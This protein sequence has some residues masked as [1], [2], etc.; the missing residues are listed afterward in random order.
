M[1]QRFITLLLICSANV[2]WAQIYETFSDNNFTQPLWIGD[3]SSFRINASF[4][5]QLNTNQTGEYTLVTRMDTALPEVW[6]FWI[7][8]AFNPSTQNFTRFYLLSDSPDLTGIPNGYGVQLGGITGN[9]DSIVFF[10]QKG[11]QL[12]RLFGGRPATVGKSNNKISMRISRSPDGW[13]TCYSDTGGGRAWVSEGTVHDDEYRESGWMG[14]Y[15]KV[16]SGNGQQVYLDDI[17]AGPVWKDTVHPVLRE[18]VAEDSVTLSLIFSEPLNRNVAGNHQNYRMMPDDEFAAW[19]NIPDSASHRVWLHFEKP[20]KAMQLYEM[21][22]TGISDTAGNRLKD[23]GATFRYIC[24]SEFDVVI[25][26]LMPDPSPPVDLPETEYLELYNNSGIELNLANWTL[27]DGTTT[28]VLPEVYLQPDSFLIVCSSSNKDLLSAFGPVLALHVFPTLNNSEDE[29]VLRNRKGVNIHTIRYNLSAYRDPGKS[30]GGWSLEMTN[31]KR[32]CAGIFNY[33][34][35]S[36]LSGG[37]PGKRNAAWTTVPDT[38]PPGLVNINAID[39]SVLRV[40][41]N[42]CMDS[43][44]LLHSN[45]LVWPQL[46]V[47]DRQPGS[48]PF[49]TLMLRTQPLQPNT[50]YHFSISG[51]QDCSGNHAEISAGYEYLHAGEALWN[52]VLITEIMANPIGAPAL[53][54]VEFV[55][56]HNRSGHVMSTRNW[57]L[58]DRSTKSTC[59]EYFIKPDS[60]VL[61]VPS[62]AEFQFPGIPCLGLYPFPSLGNE[63]DQL[64]L[65][66]DSGKVLHTVSY[67]KDMF[68][69]D[70]KSEGGWSLEMM[71]RLNPCTEKGNWGASR[72]SSGGTPGAMNSV[73][74]SNPDR[75]APE[76]RQ[77]YP[78]GDRC[79]EIR[80]S[81]PM[82]PSLLRLTG[83]YR[84][85][86]GIGPDSLQLMEPDYREVRLYFGK[87]FQNQTVYGLQVKQQKD[88]AGNDLD[89]YR[90]YP[91]AMPDSIMPGDL[92]INEVLFNPGSGGSDFVEVVNSSKH[93]I[94]LRHIIL[95]NGETDGQN[96]ES[97]KPLPDGYLMAPGSY[98]VF[99]PDPDDILTRFTCASPLQIIS[100]KLPSLPDDAGTVSLLTGAET[101]IESFQY[102]N[103]MHNPFVNQQDGVSLERIQSNRP[104]TDVTNWTSAA[105]T[106][107]YGTPTQVNSQFF[108]SRETESVLQVEPEL[109]S[110]DY[111][112]FKDLIHFSYNLG[113]AGFVGQMVLYHESGRPVRTLM[114]NAVLGQ[115]GTI[116]WD[117]TSDQNGICPPGIY[118]VIFECFHAGGDI[119]HYKRAFALGGKL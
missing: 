85:E 3:T 18:L 26:E 1:K 71:D 15:A 113:K 43:I 72:N 51:A 114:N 112:G 50:R 73:S 91:F 36:D 13:W 14:L 42:E 67:H 54:E 10:K 115:S 56:L 101:T 2:L 99:T 88:C 108:R 98:L 48:F 45:W 82:D 12:I 97:V 37:T 32:A 19:V 77:V 8:H 33:V 61:L 55:E 65:R 94:D 117:G 49:D 38:L 90:I 64:I 44:G 60:F 5:A 110:P 39:S 116:S 92:I 59:P 79:L 41:F 105:F 68:G 34:A 4:Q 80:F 47:I 17:Y 40:V 102:H 25:S 6:E 31:P 11:N 75:Q 100:C 58:S 23:T 22:L 9:N 29:F 106:C 63:S 96:L 87:A 95:T 76:I 57:T 109:F 103:D 28:A 69:N 24:E 62:G 16:T 21:R 111:D 46:S 52:D 35:S 81:E 7:R 89:E 119:R 78:I 104:A 70:I 84:F 107:G 27:S 66:D 93:W 118:V 30:Q 83:R 20:M 53:P 74:G 86:S